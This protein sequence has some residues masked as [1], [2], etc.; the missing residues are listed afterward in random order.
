[1][2]GYHTVITGRSE[3]DCYQVTRWHNTDEQ[4]TVHV[5]SSTSGTYI[6]LSLLLFLSFVLSF[7]W[8]I[9]YL[10]SPGLQEL[11]HTGWRHSNRPRLLYHRRA[12]PAFGFHTL[13]ASL[14]HSYL[15]SSICLKCSKMSERSIYLFAHLFDSRRTSMGWPLSHTTSTHPEITCIH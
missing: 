10:S 11:Q 8:L 2:W 12:H 4:H 1:M 6:P 15:N 5:C 7:S 9:G 14:R 3:S 13:F